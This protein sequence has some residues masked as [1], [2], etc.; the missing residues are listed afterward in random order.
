[1]GELLLFEKD[2]LGLICDALDKFWLIKLG[3]VVWNDTWVTV[4]S[5]CLFTFSVVSVW[6]NGAILLIKFIK[7]Y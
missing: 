3:A 1:M 2:E 5:N 6:E 7:N 4:E